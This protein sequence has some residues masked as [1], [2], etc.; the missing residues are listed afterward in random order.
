MRQLVR[1]LVVAIVL[2]QGVLVFA[3]GDETDAGP[4]NVAADPAAQRIGSKLSPDEPLYFALGWNEGLNARFQLSFKYRF[5]N[6]EGVVTK[7]APFFS[8]MYFAYTQTSLWDLESESKPFF[9]TSYKPGLTYRDDRVHTSESGLFRIRGQ[10]GF[11][12]ESNGQGGDESRSL[13]IF[14]VR[15]FFE[16]EEALGTA[17]LVVAPKIWS[18]VG[19]LT[20]NPDIAEYRGYGELRVAVTGRSEWQ[21]AATF[22]M[23]TSGKGS[24]LF[25]FTYPMD[26]IAWK[27]FDA[28]LHVQYFNGWGE[29]LRSYNQKLPSQIRIG[30]AAYR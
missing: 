12:H 15:P 3:Q 2:V 23:G 13:N 30:I 20:D 22:R 5:V 11:E 28:F 24:V 1:R 4:A 18:Y 10:V 17:D 9:D 16:F 6:P 21:T 14:F 7:R 8:H 26:R 25:D 19:G 27:T 29:S